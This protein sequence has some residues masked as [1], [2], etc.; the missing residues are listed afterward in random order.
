METERAREKKPEGKKNRTEILL[1]KPRAESQHIRGA[2]AEY[3]AQT[4]D[5]LGGLERLTAG[6]KAI[7][8]AQKTALLVILC[9][10]DELVESGNLTGDDGKPNSLLKI[11]E[12]YLTVF[13]QGQVALGLGSPRMMRE[14]GP[15]LRQI[16]KEYEARAARPF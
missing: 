4:T 6:Q 5:E 14:D 12:S 15:T 13:R 3:V 10:E 16:M 7:L 11:L 9:Y 2:I 1:C 8:L